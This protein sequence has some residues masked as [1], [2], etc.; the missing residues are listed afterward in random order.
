MVG[1]EDQ[2]RGGHA[3]GGVE[4]VLRVKDD[5]DDG[6]E[7]PAERL[8]I[9][10]SHELAGR[11]EELLRVGEDRLVRD[12]DYH[13]DDRKVADLGAVVQ[14]HRCV[15]ELVPGE[16]LLE[17]EAGGS[18]V[19]AAAVQRG[20]PWKRPSVGAQTGVSGAMTVTVRYW[21]VAATSM[22]PPPA[23]GPGVRR[24]A[25]GTALVVHS[26]VCCS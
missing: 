15:V 3:A 16:S 10:V 8:A 21:P 25:P 2:L 7:A 5:L 26:W 1:R 20:W 6:P 24:L 4:I 19:S 22:E 17:G 11:V 9:L 14:A 18:G 12:R 23:G 13:G